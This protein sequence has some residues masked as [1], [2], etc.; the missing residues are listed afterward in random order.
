MKAGFDFKS[1]MM[2]TLKRGL[3]EN[4]REHMALGELG[5]VDWANGVLLDARR[6]A[7]IRSGKLRRSGRVFRRKPRKPSFHLVKIRF[8]SKRKGGKRSRRTADYAAIVHFNT[9]LKHRTGDAM[10]LYDAM[11]KRSAQ[12]PA[13]ISARW[14]VR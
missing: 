8:G 14:K 12:M 1:S 9:N 11:A 5:V 2:P 3:R 4:F 13:F 6:L 10:F 7:P